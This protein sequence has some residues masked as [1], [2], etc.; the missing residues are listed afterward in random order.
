MGTTG[1]TWYEK[2]RRVPPLWQTDAT[3]GI[4]M[5]VRQFLLGQSDAPLVHK[6]ADYL[7]DYAEQ[8]WAK[9][10]IRDQGQEASNPGPWP[11]APRP[12]SLEPDS[13]DSPELNARQDD[14]L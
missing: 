10:G 7:A 5:L 13:S 14:D 8:T 1:R 6:A 2:R 3:T 11:L 4:G 9:R 12:S